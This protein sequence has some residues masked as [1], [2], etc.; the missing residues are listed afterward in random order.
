ML[1]QPDRAAY[2]AA[3]VLKMAVPIRVSEDDVGSTVW[4]VFVR[5]VKKTAKIWL[6]S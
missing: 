2:H 5:P 1:V 3:I 6:Y 4:A